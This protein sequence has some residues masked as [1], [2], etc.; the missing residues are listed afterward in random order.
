[1]TKNQMLISIVLVLVSLSY[2][3]KAQ[4]STER[5]RLRMAQTHERGGDLRNAA[6]LYQELFAATPSSDAYFQG[7]VRTLGG[8]QQFAALLPLVESRAQAYPDVNTAILAGTLNA[9]IGNTA[10]AE[11]WWSEAIALSDDDETTNVLIGAEQT[12]LL[13]N[14]Q[15]LKSYKAARAINGAPLVYGD[16]ISQLYAATG[17]LK[18]AAREALAIYASDGEIIRAQRRLS[19]LLSYENGQEILATQL[20]AL[21]GD[22]Q[23]ILRLRQWF[24]KQTKNWRSALEVTEKLDEQSQP[25]GQELLL[26]A[27]GARMDNQFDIAIAAYGM[28]MKEGPDQRYRMSAAYGSARALEQKLRASSSITAAEARAIIE[29]YDE[30]IKQYSQHPLAAEALYQSAILEDDVIG[31]MDESRQR[32]MRLQ[33]QWRGTT[34]SIDGALRLADIY[35]AMGKDKDAESILQSVVAGPTNVSADRRDRAKLRLADIHF[36]NG[37]L[38]SARTLYEP[39]AATTGSVASNDALDHLLLINLAQEDSVAVVS[40]AKAEGLMVR[41]LYREAAALFSQASKSA[42]QGELRDRAAINAARAYID[43]RDD[44]AA[45]P[46]LESIINGIP[47]TIFGDRA[48]SLKADIQIRRGDKK[49]AL[50]TLDSLL[51]NYPRSILVPTIRDRIRVLRGD[52]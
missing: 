35:F 23:E 33:N 38:D 10:S 51:V 31:N 46:L 6:R 16:E 4:Q 41:R 42:S 30:I 48:L 24:Y 39:L 14:A 5:D 50:L 49:G 18:G 13:M 43:L 12:L 45:E 40:I 25:R 44:A 28:I 27:D 8:L 21:S 2:S 22:G 11:K 29:K 36:W 47:E 3:V 19:V 52:A 15:A 20:N 1:M 26:F 9:K 37:K 7:V 32:L 34:A 17:D